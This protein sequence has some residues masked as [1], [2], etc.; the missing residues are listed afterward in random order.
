MTNI[1]FI[2]FNLPCLIQNNVRKEAQVKAGK[3]FTHYY[4]I[5]MSSN[6]RKC[7]S[8]RRILTAKK[9]SRLAVPFDKNN[10]FWKTRT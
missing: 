9:L 8:R 5:V 3:H 1:V 6:T 4:K 7:H 10:A 2:F